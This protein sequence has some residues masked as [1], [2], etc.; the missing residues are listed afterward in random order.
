M[1]II[2][3]RVNKVRDLKKLNSIY[4]TEIDIRFYKQKLILNH[5][6][7]QTGD[8]LEDY[9]INYSHGTLVLNIKEAG[10]ELEVLKLVKKYSIKNYFLLDIEF[11]FIL[12]A[13]INNIRELAIRV[14]FYES[15][16]NVH[17]FKNLFNWIWLDSYKFKNFNKND[18]NILKKNKICIVCPSRW[19]KENQIKKYKNYFKKQNIKLHAVMTEKKYIKYWSD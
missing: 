13:Y 16:T 3:H 2:I 17:N 5:E 1:E 14:S 12:N 18:L 9:L 10:I 19:G 7:N 11:P 4:G 6:P 8:A 15:T